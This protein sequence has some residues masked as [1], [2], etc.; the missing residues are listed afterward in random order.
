M[1]NGEFIKSISFKKII[2]ISIYSALGLTIFFAVSGTFGL[3]IGMSPLTV[4]GNKVFGYKGFLFLIISL[5]LYWL[6]IFLAHAL[7]LSIG[8]WISK[9]VILFKRN[10]VKDKV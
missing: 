3:F 8:L 10:S 5:P 4:D 9:N 1:N 6:L 7:M 2:L